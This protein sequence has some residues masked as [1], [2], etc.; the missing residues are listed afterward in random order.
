MESIIE[1]KGSTVLGFFKGVCG[2]VYVIFAEGTQAAWLYELLRSS[3]AKVTC[4][5]SYA[6]FR[7]LRV[8]GEGVLTFA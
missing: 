7:S 6:V 2:T 3:S 5:A 1:T 4:Q 8:F